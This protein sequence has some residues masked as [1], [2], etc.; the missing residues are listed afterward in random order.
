MKLNHILRRQ[1]GF[2]WVEQGRILYAF[3]LQILQVRYRTSNHEWVTQLQLHMSL[4]GTAIEIFIR[5]SFLLSH[6]KYAYVPTCD[7]VKVYDTWIQL[8]ATD[9]FCPIILALI[10]SSYFFG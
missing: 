4:Y 10:T 1:F 9:L 2:T 7:M 3:L 5:L 8:S 6:L